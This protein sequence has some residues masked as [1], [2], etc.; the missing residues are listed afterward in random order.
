M[1]RHFTECM[2]LL[3]CRFDL[4]EG[5][6]F[7][8]I[9]I[10]AAHKELTAMRDFDAGKEGLYRRIKNGAAHCQLEFSSGINLASKEENIE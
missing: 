7:Q 6:I 2:N 4:S 8:L 5:E 10:G 9:S 1:T 3:R